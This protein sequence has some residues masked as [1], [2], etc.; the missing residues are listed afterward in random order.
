MKKIS[1]QFYFAP[2]EFVSTVNSL[3]FKN[4]FITIIR[5]ADRQ[6]IVFDGEFQELY[7]DLSILC[8]GFTA[9]N[10]NL[11]GLGRNGFR[12]KN[13]ESL[14]FEVGRVTPDGLAQSWIAAMTYDEK[15]SN[16]WGRVISKFKRSLNSGITA[17]NR[18]SGVQARV[19]G[20]YY[21]DGAAGL[22]KNGIPILPLIGSKGPI[23]LLE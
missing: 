5:S 6:S 1:L 2:D 16:S 20:I 10:P 14:I 17:I 19:K 22:Y 13:K 8:I 3:I 7:K 21:T 11:T 23:I 4:A 18:D 9:V 15:I 12:E